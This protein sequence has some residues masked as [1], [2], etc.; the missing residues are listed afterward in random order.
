MRLG[1]KEKMVVG[2]RMSDIVPSLFLS[3]VIVLVLALVAAVIPLL[4]G[5]GRDEAGAQEYGE[6][7]KSLDLH[8]CWV[9]FVMRVAGDRS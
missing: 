3:A 2:T 1:I 5:Q 8:D 7:G 6:A 9:V 4:V